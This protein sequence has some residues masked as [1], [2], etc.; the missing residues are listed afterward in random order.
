MYQLL[1]SKFGVKIASV[2]IGLTV[3]LFV[4]NPELLSFVVLA[5]TIGID[6]LLL[7]IGFQLRGFFE[8]AYQ[9]TSFYFHAIFKRSGK[10]PPPKDDD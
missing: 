9:I 10:L 8:T 7:L 4:T 1:R 5:N 3:I 2:L 6:F